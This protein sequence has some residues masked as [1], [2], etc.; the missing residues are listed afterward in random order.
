MYLEQYVGK[1][2]FIRTRDKRWTEPFGLP[3]ELFLGRIRAVDAQGIWIEWARYPLLNRRTNEKRFFP[4]E[5]FIPH[6][7]VAAMFAS[8]EFQR[9]VEAQAD[10]QRLAN[11]EPAGEG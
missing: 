4:G 6:D 10:A 5:L 11:V 1:M 9:D 7:N 2:V 8:Q 3:S